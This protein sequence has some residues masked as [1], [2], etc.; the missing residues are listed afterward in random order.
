MEDGKIKEK[1]RKRYSE[2]IK[3]KNGCCS[4]S[5]DSCGD[6]LI[7]T[8]EKIGYS[9]EDMKNIPP[10]SFHGLGCG[11]PVALAELKKGERVL[12]LGSGAGVDVFMAA[13]KVGAQ[14]FVIGVDMSVH[15]VKKPE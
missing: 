6:D 10:E 5:C 15:M 14:G 4:C 3:K 9:S 1:V 8:A 2:V 11:N 7:Q 13:N 12:D